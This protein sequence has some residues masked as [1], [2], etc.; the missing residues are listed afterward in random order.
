[1]M[2]TTGLEGGFAN[3]PV[4]SAQTFR[5]VLNAMAHPG[6]IETVSAA[7][8]PL[9]MDPAAGAMLLTLADHETKIFLAPSV[10]SDA[11]RSWLTFH[12]GAP[13]VASGAADFAIGHWDELLPIDQYQ[14]GTAA[15]P[16]RSVT[17]VVTQP[18]LTDKGTVI[19]GPGIQSTA[20]LNI[21]DTALLDFNA[22]RSPLGIDM[23]MTAGD[24]LAAVPR[25]TRVFDREKR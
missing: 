9:P 12:T 1:M 22:N 10:D 5:A 24:Q 8:P 25:S 16:D 6:R 17:L 4:K 23:I 2:A 14:I 19:C 11:I 15:Y 20:S 18:A 21:P 3:A 13:L 7:Q